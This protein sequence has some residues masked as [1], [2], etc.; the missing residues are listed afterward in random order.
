MKLYSVIPSTLIKKSYAYPEINISDDE[1]DQLTR[2]QE[3]MLGL[4]TATAG[5][6]LVDSGLKDFKNNNVVISYGA[7]KTM[8][9]GHKQPASQI[10][11]L[12]E[13]IKSEDKN[14]SFLSKLNIVDAPV[15]DYEGNISPEVK[16]KLKN[17]FLT[18]IDTGWGLFDVERD[19]NKGSKPG[20]RNIK[21]RISG[22]KVIQRDPL[23]TRKFRNFLSFQ[24]DGRSDVTGYLA[25]G[26]A[27]RIAK[28]RNY[29]T[30]TYG[31]FD[32]NVAS[33]LSK[34]KLIYTGRA[35][36]LVEVAGLDKPMDRKQ[37]TEFISDYLKNKAGIKDFDPSIFDGKKIISVSGATRGDT[38][39]ARSRWVNDILRAQGRN[40]DDY[41]VLGFGGQNW[42]REKLIANAGTPQKNIFIG[43]LLDSPAAFQNAINNSDLH[44]MGMGGS[45]P[46]ESLAHGGSKLAVLNDEQVFRSEKNLPWAHS[47]LQR[48][49]GIHAL[50]R[51]LI[52]Q[53][54]KNLPE[55]QKLLESEPRDWMNMSE[56]GFGK[57]K[58]VL[59]RGLDGIRDY[60][61]L[62]GG[63][64]FDSNDG[65]SFLEALDAPTNRLAAEADLTRRDI[66]SGRS[67]VKQNL[68]KQL[69]DA[70]LSS[71]ILGGK[72][73]LGALGA[74]LIGSNL[75]F[76]EREKPEF[77]KQFE[78]KSSSSDDINTNAQIAGGVASTLGGA[79]LYDT[80]RSLDKIRGISTPYINKINKY[81]KKYPELMYD[82]SPQRAN[83][84][85]DVMDTY[86]DSAKKLSNLRVM[87][88]PAKYITSKLPLAPLVSDWKSTVMH[89]A[90]LGDFIDPAKKWKIIDSAEHYREAG[91]NPRKLLS[92]EM[93]THMAGPN[94]RISND[95]AKVM[96]YG[97][98]LDIINAP[99][100]VSLKDRFKNYIAL[101]NDNKMNASDWERNSP[102]FAREKR[103]IRGLPD[104]VN[105]T[106]ELS[107]AE[108]KNAA[109]LEGI[110]GYGLRFSNYAKKI[111]P[112]MKLTGGILAGLGLGLAGSGIHN[113]SKEAP[114]IQN[115]QIPIN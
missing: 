41:I 115:D 91:N 46:P 48:N 49:K 5:G 19:L 51:K 89:A 42:E 70:K 64:M 30:L 27:N 112:K 61:K 17:R 82:F 12:I 84:F 15:L 2:P 77:F 73:M 58:K 96:S 87:G 45:G 9:G 13:E 36:P 47:R 56:H 31:D 113:K 14:K 86:S 32:P 10:R 37:Y 20:L 108:L 33:N 1:R 62:R 28:L 25:T 94:V 79:A 102:F 44:L 39:G 52:K 104:H 100:N 111:A 54:N 26:D 68:L 93:L 22:E 21:E 55:G 107:K 66:L 71:K 23:L 114:N 72:K 97:D 3:K 106:G 65:K 99:E 38:V 7:G 103:M 75:M 16:G 18:G 81:I 11:K 43:P 63:F 101:A 85:L 88:I 24:P 69:K 109:R 76:K 53:V 40:P 83:D 74:G 67:V 78:K 4:G 6:L 110:K 50:E 60:I 59:R 34:G 92:R 8:G 98:A 95:A 90:G 35:H 57:N 29:K 105:Y 80:G